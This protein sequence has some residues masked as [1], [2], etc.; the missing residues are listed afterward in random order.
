MTLVVILCLCLVSCGDP[1]LIDALKCRTWPA[2]CQ[3]CATTT[4]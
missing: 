4:P 3:Q 2:Y 1:D